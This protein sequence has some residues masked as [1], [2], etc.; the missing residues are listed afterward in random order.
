MHGIVG[1]QRVEVNNRGRVIRT[2][3]VDAPTPGQDLVLTLDIG[4][5]QVAK[6]ALEGMRGAIVVMDPKEMGARQFFGKHPWS[7][8]RPL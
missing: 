2:L 7:H 3:S 5:Q 8:H 1:S 4:L 6:K